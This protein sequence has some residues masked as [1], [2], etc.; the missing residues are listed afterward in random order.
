[1]TEEQK[2][3]VDVFYKE[4]G[5]L[6]IKHN[7]DFASYPVFVPDGEGGFKIVVQSTPVDIK[8]RP[9]KSPFIPQ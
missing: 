4:Y 6:V 8:D 5:D 3:R 2:Q 7:V 1:M 9:V